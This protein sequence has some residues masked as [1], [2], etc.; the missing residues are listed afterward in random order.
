M[1]LPLEA[2]KRF[3]RVTDENHLL[4]QQIDSQKAVISD[5]SGSLAETEAIEKDLQAVAEQLATV[6]RRRA[7]ASAILLEQLS[8][9][10]NP[11]PSTRAGELLKA[12]LSRIQLCLSDLSLHGIKQGSMSISVIA[13]IELGEQIRKIIEDLQEKGLYPETP[14]EAEERLA[15]THEHTASVLKFMQGFV[16]SHESE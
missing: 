5:V 7:E 9:S 6:D 13:L 11:P 16:K 12:L 1:L 3:E 10:A 2:H 8:S 15:K 14:E 4:K